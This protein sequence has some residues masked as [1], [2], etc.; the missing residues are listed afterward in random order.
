MLIVIDGIIG[1][2]KTTLLHNCLIPGLTS[3]GYKVV[4]IKEPVDKWEKN[5]TLVEFYSDIKRYAYKF[6]TM[7]FH[8]RVRETQRVF[9]NLDNHSDNKLI[10]LSERSIFTDR[11]F[12]KMLFESG[13]M[14]KSEYDSYSDLWTMWS[15]VMPIKPSLFVYLKPTVS[16]SMKRISNRGRSGE[17]VSLEY[18]MNL[19]KEHDNMYKD[20]HIIISDNESIP[21]IKIETDEDFKNDK[22]VQEKIL[23]QIVQNINLRFKF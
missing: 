16:E 21:C 13:N 6:Q 7:A 12:A 14:T 2:G 3:R 11:V 9:A 8:D 19:A 18:Q 23:W 22:N 20:D 5:G 4:L 17:E 10:I 1:A 15:E